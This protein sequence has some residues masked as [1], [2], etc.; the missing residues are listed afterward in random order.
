M[1]KTVTVGL[2]L[3]FIASLFATNGMNMIGYGARSSAMGGFS[4]GLIDVNSTNTNPAVISFINQRK[5][6]V[7]LG[8]LIPK[9][10]FENS[11]NDLESEKKVFPLPNFSYVNG[12][13]N[14][15]TWGLAFYSQGGMGATFKD[16]KHN[17]FRN[18]DMNPQTQDD[19]FID[20]LEYHSMIG[21]MKITP[22]L[23]YKINDNFSVG[24]APN[25]G[26]ATMEMKMP[27][28]MDAAVMKG[29]A[30][31]ESGMTFGDMFGAPMD[32]GGLGYEEVTAYADMGDAISAYGFG[33]RLGASYKLNDMVSFGVAYG[34]KSSLTFEGEAKMDMTAQFGQAYER[35][36]S[37]AL[38]QMGITDI[39]AATSEEIQQAS[40]G[41]GNQFGGMG[42]DMSLGMVADYDVE[43][44]MAWPQEF[45]MGM[46]FTPNP[47]LLLGIDVKWINWKEAMDEFK[48][49]FTEG[50]NANI[51]TMMGSEDIKLSMPLDWDDQIVIALGAEYRMNENIALRCG[52]NY[53]NNPV[54]E[55]TIIPIFPAVIENHA[56]LGLGY[57]LTEKLGIDAAYEMNFEKEVEVGNSI[58]ANE[59]E[60]ST[61]SLSENVVHLGLRYKF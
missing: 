11:L 24:L 28:S 18:Y 39:S 43:V 33:A 10:K 4:L 5:M 14:K 31:P 21:F 51:N 46:S 49:K 23:A 17:I 59:Y 40:Q 1:K 25:F 8:L 9:V 2:M 6:D 29:V 19:A 12:N 38:M 55:E 15:C 44:Q 57:E 7:T 30:D 13:E 58:I 41:V 27:Y 34:S 26:Y 60:N 53:A 56:T 52:Y 36:V 47:K 35:M 54:P 45:G 32:Q 37:G 50:S 42:I 3:I 48:M 22:S 16:V 20:D 61:Q